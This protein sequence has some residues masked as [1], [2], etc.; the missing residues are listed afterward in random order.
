MVTMPTDSELIDL[1]AAET[2]KDRS[3]LKLD[4]TLEQIDIDSV[5]LVSM[6]FA[7][8]DKY[9]VHVQYE[10]VSRDQTLGTVLGL[11]RDKIKQQADQA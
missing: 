6:F 9:G 5:D 8:E 3:V 11:V 7:L 1:I 10:E 4:S 2:L